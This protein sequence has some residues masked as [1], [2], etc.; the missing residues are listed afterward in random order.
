MLDLETGT[1]A[2]AHTHSIALF[3]CSVF[4]DTNVTDHTQ[5]ES[6]LKCFILLRVNMILHCANNALA[7]DF[8]FLESSNNTHFMRTEV[9]NTAVVVVSA[10][11]VIQ[12]E[13][14]QK[15]RREKECERVRGRERERERARRNRLRCD[16]Q[17]EPRSL[18]RMYDKMMNLAHL[19]CV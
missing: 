10:V 7:A 11:M 9:I 6:K 19:N 2:R 4:R 5:S 18:S 15:K 13:T 17:L 16:F 8:S 14:V 1:N 3:G 12:K